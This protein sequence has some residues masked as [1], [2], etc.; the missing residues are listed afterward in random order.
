M[1]ETG[2][3]PLAQMTEVKTVRVADYIAR[4]VAGLGA[5]AFFMVSGGMMMHLMD[6]FGRTSMRYYCNHHEQACAMAA[7]AY[8]RQ[9]GKLGVCLATSGPGATNLL[10]GLVGAY[11]DSVPVLFL[12]GQCKRKETVHWRGLKGLRQCGFL[13]VDI[14]PIVESVT[15]YAAFV[16][17]P[18]DIR[19]HLEKAIHLATTGRPGPVLLDL[20][21]DV[22]GAAVDPAEMRPYIP[23]PSAPSSD[24]SPE[25]LQRVIDAVRKA[26]RPLLLAGHGVRSAG[27][28]DEFRS[29]VELWQV[30][31]ATTFMAK[32]LVPDEHPL[33]VGHPGPRGNRGANFAVQS[34]DV[35]LTMGCSL[36]LQTVGYEG[37]LFAPKALKIQIDLDRA[38]LQRDSTGAQWKFAWDLHEYLPALAREATPHCGLGWQT[39]CRAWKQSHSSRNEPHVFG[40]SGDLVN[41]YEFVDQLSDALSGDETV[42]TD[43]GQPHPI[44]AQ[45]FRQKVGQRYLNPGS[46]AEMGWA[47]PASLG[48][49][50]A[51]PDRQVVSVF[52][53]GSLQTNIQELQTLAHHQFNIKTFVI[54]NDGYASIRNTQK[55]FF[56]GFFVGS[57]PDSGVT[58]PDLR[59]ICE[60][61]GLPYVRCE[62]RGVL[63]Q[64]LREVLDAKGPVICEVM[65]QVDQRILPVV[66]SSLLP[67]GSMRSKALHEM[68]PVLPT[69]TGEP[70]SAPLI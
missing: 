68:V 5:D 16:D 43:A 11:Q 21:L 63:A 64:R 34:A 6:A 44:L 9:T 48:V 4:T 51:A 24:F 69:G 38:L 26:E 70:G 1:T 23:E 17:E 52:G 32:D 27:L 60:A 12:T 66:P 53:D 7:D 40:G 10:T 18:A 15:K 19:Y 56:Q 31:V 22:Q 33:F 14:V 42:L 29:L 58:L 25:D 65:A 49:A 55:N 50:V 20:P 54:S 8:S 67:D 37:D 3:A 46:L 30:P 59:K 57:T 13:E 36:H 47:L 39:A 61:Y 35:I 2:T 62:N 28:V 45:A 41:L